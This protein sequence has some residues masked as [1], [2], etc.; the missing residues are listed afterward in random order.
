MSSW[1]AEKGKR[2]W[3]AMAS[4]PSPLSSPLE[5]RGMNP[6]PF[7][8]KAKDRLDVGRGVRLS[9]YPFAILGGTGPC[10]TH[11]TFVS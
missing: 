9:S 5:E 10:S 11:R 1:G 7:S 6:P 3:A 2:W 8:L 4:R